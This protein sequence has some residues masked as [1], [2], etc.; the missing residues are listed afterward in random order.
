ML[1]KSVSAVVHEK[2]SLPSVPKALGSLRTG[3][4]TRVSI[5]ITWGQVARP[6]PQRVWVGLGW[7]LSMCISNKFPDDFDAAGQEPH[8]GNHSLRTS[9]NSEKTDGKMPCSCELCCGL[10]TGFAAYR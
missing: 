6:H 10:T 1:Q 8:L 5:R 2:S 4:H 3:S 7:G 9:E